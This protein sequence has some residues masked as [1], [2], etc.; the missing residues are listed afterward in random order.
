MSGGVELLELVGLD[1]VLQTLVEVVSHEVAVSPVDVNQRS[2]VIAL[3]LLRRL[4]QLL[5]QAS[6]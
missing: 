4:R 3:S 5:Y 2:Y 1:V 6:Q